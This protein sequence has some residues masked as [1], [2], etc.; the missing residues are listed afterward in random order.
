MFLFACFGG[1]CPDVDSYYFSKD[2]SR[3]PLTPEPIVAR[4]PQALL[5][6]GALAVIAHVDRAFSYG[7]EDVMGTPQAN[8]LRAPLELL[9]RGRDVGLA[10]E[11]LNL[12]WS[13]L[14][15]QLGIALGG[16][17]PGAA[18][19]RCSPTWERSGPA[20]CSTTACT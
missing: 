3:L 1:G 17:A 18:T 5:T 14:A 13:N 2:G 20:S 8:L 19:S 10:A 15:A 12:Q 16:N 11:P 9:A 4:L 6:R 7:F